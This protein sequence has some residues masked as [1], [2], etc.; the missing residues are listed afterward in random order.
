MTL[1]VDVSKIKEKLNKQSSR[2]GWQQKE[3]DVFKVTE[4]GK[5]NLRAVIYPHSQDPS[6]E[7]FL[8]RHYHFGIPGGGTFYC[9]SKNEGQK[10]HVCD[11]IWGK[12]KE[13]KGN[14]EAIKKWS[15][16]LP[17]LSVLVPVLVRGKESEGVKFFRINSS[18]KAGRRSKNHDKLYQW[19]IDD[20]TSSWLD[21]SAGFDVVVTYSAPDAAKSAFLG[22]AKAILDNIELAR[23]STKFGTDEEYNEFISS[24]KNVDK[25]LFPKKTTEDS[26]ALLLK[27][28]EKLAPQAALEVSDD[29]LNADDGLSL[30][31]SPPPSTEVDDIDAK[32]AAFEDQLK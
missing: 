20:E 29:D 27:W 30:A 9:P 26:M 6:A 25:E 11:F 32:L 14:K 16:F 31:G 10:C 13:N 28:R 22:N 3:S 19:T 18:D 17:K 7:P 24:V 2:A 23:K 5:Y 12:M 8:E 15:G 21:P 1:K 4:P